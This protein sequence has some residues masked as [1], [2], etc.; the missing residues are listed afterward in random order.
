[1]LS[2]NAMESWNWDRPGRLA[3]ASRYSTR[4]TAAFLD[5]YGYGPG[6]A[7]AGGAARDAEADPGVHDDGLTGEHTGEQGG[8]EQAETA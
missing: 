4:G 8:A 6:A 7:R 1:M 2:L 3:G 5:E